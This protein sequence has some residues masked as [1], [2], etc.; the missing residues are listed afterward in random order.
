[1]KIYFDTE[2]TGLKK[3]TTL[4]SIGLITEEDETFYAELTDFD[5]SYKDEWFVKNV[6]DHLLLDEEKNKRKKKQDTFVYVPWEERKIAD[7]TIRGT[8]NEVSYEL[9]RWLKHFV[10]IQLVS[11]VCHYDMVLFIDLFGGAFDLLPSINPVCHDINQDIAEFCKITEREAFD[12]NREK[13]L[14]ENGVQLPKGKKH[15]SLYDAK[16][17]K[18]IDDVIRRSVIDDVRK[19]SFDVP[20]VIRESIENRFEKKGDK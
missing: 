19:V 1:M 4:V 5:K 16:V 6:L 8:K 13:F 17:I 3:D 9:Y 12:K 20:N 2:F 7:K 14:L 10:S 15:N 11:D 18:M